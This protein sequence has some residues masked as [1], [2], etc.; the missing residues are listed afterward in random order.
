MS[1]TEKFILLAV[2]LV[3]AVLL[4]V[5]L[6]R[7]SAP[8][9][10][11][12]GE[13]KAPEFDSAAVLGTP[14]NCDFDRL[15]TL[16]LNADATVSLYVSPIVENGRAQVFFFSD[17]ANTAWVRLRITDK[18][19]NLLG[20]TGLLRPGEYV[21]YVALENAPQKSDAF[22]RILTYEP[23]TYYS[24]GSANLEIELDMK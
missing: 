13:F 12:R 11:V 15:G 1:K 8:V 3:A 16:S 6:L 22:V 19:G 14:E 21:E 2:A 20:Q 5:L 18:K 10:V 23:E 17:D 9:Q 24:L 7:P 4:A